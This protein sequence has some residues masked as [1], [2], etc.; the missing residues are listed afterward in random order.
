MLE[1]MKKKI[2]IE[3]VKVVTNEVYKHGFFQHAGFILGMPKETKEN[4]RNTIR[5]AKSLPIDG[6]QFSIA[7]PYPGT[8]LFDIADQ[9]GDF[10]RGDY[11]NMAT[12]TKEPVFVANGLT[13]EYLKKMQKKAYREFYFRPSYVL[14]QLRLIRDY[15]NFMKYTHAGLSHFK[16]YFLK[17]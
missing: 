15:N 14:R 3:Q 7:V 9:Y 2:D 12:F 16:L 8:E 10:T 13:R 11:K 4:I 1:M 17:K 6:V 5:F